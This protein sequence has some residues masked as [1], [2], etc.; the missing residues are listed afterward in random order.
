MKDF[1]CAPRQGRREKAS[2]TLLELPGICNWG[3]ATSLRVTW[4]PI[5]R[6]CAGENHSSLRLHF[7]MSPC[8]PARLPL[9]AAG[10][11]SPTRS[12]L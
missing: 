6:Q 5:L 10:R 1:D 4:L 7:A 11:D 3:L 2:D 9:P 12:A 8:F